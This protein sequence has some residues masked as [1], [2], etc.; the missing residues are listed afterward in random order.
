MRDIL[1]PG[2]HLHLDLSTYVPGD[3]CVCDGTQILT[4]Q[5]EEVRYRA[6]AVIPHGNWRPINKSE[7]ATLMS[8]VYP[9]SYYNTVSIV[10]IDKYLLCDI[11]NIINKRIN[12]E[13]ILLEDILINDKNVMK[14]MMDI[15]DYVEKFNTAPYKLFT[16]LAVNKPYLQT[17]T[18]DRQ[19]SLYLG[20]H[21]DSFEGTPLVARDFSANRICVN[22]SNAD[23]FFLFIN[24]TLTNVMN[25][26]EELLPEFMQ[27]PNHLRFDDLPRLFSLA[28][29]NYPVVRVRCRPGTA[30]IAPTENVIHDGSS[31]GQTESDVAASVRGFF[32]PTPNT[33]FNDSEYGDLDLFALH[34]FLTPQDCKKLIDLSE[35]IR[36]FEER[37]N[38]D[39]SK[40]VL[41]NDP[42]CLSLF[43][44]QLQAFFDSS[45]Y[46]CSICL[47]DYVEIYF[48][49]SRDLDNPRQ[50]KVMEICKGVPARHTLLVYL[51]ENFVGGETVI[52]GVSTV[53]APKQG[54]GIILSKAHQYD[55]GRVLEGTQIILRADIALLP[56]SA[57]ARLTSGRS[58]D[59][60]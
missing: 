24:K 4:T 42:Q 56:P 35:K 39:Q 14:S 29:P 8:G 27:A 7:L 50:D 3:V 45:D 59:G 6:N 57:F 44:Y 21:I 37:R 28:R 47:S 19:T 32:S 53:I 10:D 55:L 60:A 36:N 5:H 2:I 31:V 11:R 16:A 54:D 23:R 46:P 26:V 34:S 49:N 18:F 15:Y 17:V 43:R 1:E 25:D 13:H 22:L 9:E 58:A 52:P 40:K 38:A 51:N 30:Y 33:I 20:L 12:I 48:F 41:F